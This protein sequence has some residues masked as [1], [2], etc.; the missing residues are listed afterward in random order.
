[1]DAVWCESLR[2]V[3]ANKN[4][5]STFEFRS[6][7]RLPMS[8]WLPTDTGISG[9]IRNGARERSEFNCVSVRTRARDNQPSRGPS[10]M[11]Y[12]RSAKHFKCKLKRHPTIVNTVNKYIVSGQAVDSVEKKKKPNGDGKN[13]A[14][15]TG[16]HF[17]MC[18]S[19]WTLSAS[20]VHLHG[21][22]T[23]GFFI[24]SN[25]ARHLCSHSSYER[26]Y[27]CAFVCCMLIWPGIKMLSH[28]NR[29]THKIVKLYL[30]FW[31]TVCVSDGHSD[32]LCILRASREPAPA[33]R[34]RWLDRKA[35]RIGDHFLRLI[36]EFHRWRLP[37]TPSLPFPFRTAVSGTQ[38]K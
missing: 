33:K 17:M 1:M 26:V 3:V 9:T 35:S 21:V 18:L 16:I 28:R 34:L 2:K 4:D 10:K 12:A 5:F 14:R 6:Q 37:P 31:H 13:A 27:V 15:Q 24:H 7:W 32:D 25:C 23:G 30:P 20:Y 29:I 36:F 19:P 8:M 38:T 22:A 11:P